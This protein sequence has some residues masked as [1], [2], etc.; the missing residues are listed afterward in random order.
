MPTSERARAQSS[1]FILVAVLWVLS[2]LA[3]LASIYAAYVA[4]TA[5]AQAINDDTIQNESLVSAALELT[6]YRLLEQPADRRATR[7]NFSFRLGRATVAV[8]FC[9]EGARIDLNEAPK[10]MLAGLFSALGA[11]PNDAAQYADRVIG[12]RTAPK[13]GAQDDEALLYGGAGLN[14]LPRGGPFEHVGELWLVL[15]LSPAIVERA[16]AYVTVFSGRQEIT[17]RDAAP[18]V[19]AALP[20]MTPS[21][22]GE[23]F[24]QRGSNRSNDADALAQQGAASNF[25]TTEGSNATRVTIDIRPD[26]GRRAVAEAVVLLGG[27][28]EPFRVLSWRVDA[29]AVSPAPIAPGANL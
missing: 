10:E 22:L 18:E 17:V 19:L 9:S 21:R 25:M 28:D 23:L 29:D 2:A 20:G 26:N 1:G 14:Y 7:G 6:A 11:H 3:V 27:S 24:A 8:E 4:R 12:W 13:G 5:V 15:G 16:L